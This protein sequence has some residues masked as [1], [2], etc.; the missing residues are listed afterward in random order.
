MTVII[1]LPSGDLS[2]VGVMYQDGS[3]KTELW[4][5]SEIPHAA[6]ERRARKSD[7]QQ[8]EF[9]LLPGTLGS[10][11][12]TVGGNIEDRLQQALEVLREAC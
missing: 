8:G 3:L 12:V 2:I 7:V 5:R 6:S 1:C 11:G 10:L 9:E 4:T